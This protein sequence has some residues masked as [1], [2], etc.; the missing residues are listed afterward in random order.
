VNRHSGYVSYALFP[1]SRVWVYG[2]IRENHVTRV[3]RL[4]TAMSQ[5]AWRKAGL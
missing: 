1:N 3:T 2:E 4:V 5:P